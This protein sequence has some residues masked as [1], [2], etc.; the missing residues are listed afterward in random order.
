[1]HRLCEIFPWLGDEKIERLVAY[2]DLLREWNAKINLISRRDTENIAMRHIIPCLAIDAVAGFL[3]GDDVLDI[4]TGGGLP[5]IPLAI[6]RESTNFTL[7]DSIGKKIVAV[8]DM[9]SRLG[10]KNAKTING[11][12][13]E[14][15]GKFDAVVGRA[16]TNFASFLKYA[17]RLLADGGKILYLKGGDCAED[18]AT[19]EKYRLHSVGK[20]I[21]IDAL[22][23][24]VILEVR[25]L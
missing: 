14:V 24:K 4:G 12:A 5:G 11:R 3:P 2:A 6:A 8:N 21:G 13:E 22:A 25:K 7:L 17:R 18:I 1:V 15:C 16:V 19:L 10:M 9:V 20:I 23:D